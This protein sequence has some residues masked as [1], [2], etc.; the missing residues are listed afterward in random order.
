MRHARAWWVVEWPALP[1]RRF[2]RLCATCIAPSRGLMIRHPK[3]ARK[4]KTTLAKR[5]IER[6]ERQAEGQNLPLFRALISAES[7]CLEVVRPDS[8][9]GDERGRAAGMAGDAQ[10]GSKDPV[11]AHDLSCK[12][13]APPAQKTRFLGPRNHEHE[14]WYVRKSSGWPLKNKGFSLASGGQQRAPWLERYD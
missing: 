13:C 4:N 10:E 9:R 7:G 1:L 8:P 2:Q 3:C 12:W 5:G 14:T 6:R 11:R